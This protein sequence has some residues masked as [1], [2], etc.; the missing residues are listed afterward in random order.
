MA[1]AS[2]K[3]LIEGVIK[4]ALRRQ[5]P[6]VYD[7]LSDIFSRGG[8]RLR[9]ILCLAAAEAVGLRK[10]APLV[11]VASAIEMVHTFTLI[12][13]DIED[14]SE[15]RRGKSCLHRL[16]GVPLAINAGD[17]LFALAFEVAASSKLKPAVKSEILGKLAEAAVEV[18]EGQGLDIG[19]TKENR[20][21]ISEEEFLGMLRKKTGVLIAASLEIGGLY[22]GASR[23][24]LRALQRFGEAVGM[25]F[26]IQ[27][28]L[29]NLVGD[30]K[31]YGKEIG[32]DIIEGKRTLML[33]R[34]LSVAT[35]EDKNKVLAV[36][37]K[38]KKTQADIALTI[39]LMN[40]Y[41]V[42]EYAKKRSAQMINEALLEFEAVFKRENAG[43]AKIVALARQLLDRKF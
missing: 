19:W 28:D 2:E 16:H 33:I 15:L 34:F 20:F 10:V 24:Q 9:P 35:L 18:C 39:K 23:A 8:K 11:P 37:R 4:K 42:F 6:Q 41:G 14:G 43:K 12:H 1:E 7:L 3:K 27:D 5:P 36:Y 31:L 38:E 30:E 32:G 26:Q 40:D 29:L 17:A 22:A 21:N 13:D 25:A